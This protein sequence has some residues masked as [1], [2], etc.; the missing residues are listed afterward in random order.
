[1]KTISLPLQGLFEQEYI[2]KLRSVVATTNQ[3][4]LESLEGLNIELPLEDLMYNLD[5][6]NIFSAKYVMKTNIFM[7]YDE[8]EDKY[9]INKNRYTGKIGWHSK[10]EVKDLVDADLS[11]FSY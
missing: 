6:D 2:T 9:F 11:L 10:E 3:E 5:R 4:V 7:F 8:I 1:M